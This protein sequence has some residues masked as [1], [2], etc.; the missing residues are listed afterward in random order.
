M[1]A[2]GLCALCAAALTCSTCL[3]LIV[4]LCR[5]PVG[6]R[7]R[8]FPKQLLY[9]ALADVLFVVSDVPQ[10]LT[11]ERLV[12]VPPEFQAVF[13][14]YNSLM[15]PFF[16]HVS[17]WIE[18]HIAVTF[19]LRSSKVQAWKALRCSLS[20][21]WIP[22]LLLAVC[23]ALLDS[24]KYNVDAGT[25]MPTRPGVARPVDVA[26]LAL[27]VFICAGSYL[28][29]VL[30][31][32]ARRSPGSVQSRAHLRAAMYLINA[33][34]TYGLMFVCYA[35]M[36]LFEYTQLLTVAWVLE[37]LGGFF[38]SVT[39]ASQSRHKAAFTG[40]PTDVG[41]NP[42]SLPERSFDV[43]FSPHVELLYIQESSGRLTEYFSF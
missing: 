6:V 19:V 24:W 12:D 22:G 2:Q 7:E 10:I 36:Q 13:C 33:L 3:W 17:L 25:C 38:N 18:M 15:F 16:R 37:L 11:D 8:L 43:D 23:G 21:I 40:Q 42:R 29:V 39:Y 9:L 34:L 31:G 30:R 26:D 5:A 35:N 4:H 20:L 1:R 41:S 32:R 27:C 14:T 28:A